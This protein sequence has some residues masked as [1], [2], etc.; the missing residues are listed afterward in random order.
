MPVSKTR[1]KKSDKAKSQLRRYE[2][3]ELNRL[4]AMYGIRFKSVNE[5]RTIIQHSKKAEHPRDLYQSIK[6][7]FEEMIDYQF[8]PIVEM[9]NVKTP[10][11]VDS[12]IKNFGEN[13]YE[14]I[15]AANEIINQT[16]KGLEEVGN[17]IPAK[18]DG[19]DSDDPTGL[20]MGTY[21][22]V[23][24]MIEINDEFQ[25]AVIE[26][27]PLMK[28]ILNIVNKHSKEALEYQEKN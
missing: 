1:R 7:G 13:F 14:E 15:K 19:L 18:E 21:P 17:S 25:I 4:S 16:R 24:A 20:W 28:K 10:E 11:E 9:G 2:D 6:D 27:L 23:S 12:F 5:A 26:F 3:R 22:A 8:A